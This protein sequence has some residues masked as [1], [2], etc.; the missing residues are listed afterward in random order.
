MVSN[1]TRLV[2]TTILMAMFMLAGTALAQTTDYF[3]PER[4][5]LQGRW[6]RTDAP[7]IIELRPDKSNKL[8][9]TYFNKRPIHVEKTETLTKNGLQFVMIELQDINYS[10]ST[11]LLSYNRSRDSLDGVYILGGSGQ[12]FEVFFSRDTQP[13]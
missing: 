7:Y 4:L 1:Y 5:A 12:R 11:Y 3:S 2:T 9:A 10:G 6:I 8:Q 13:Q